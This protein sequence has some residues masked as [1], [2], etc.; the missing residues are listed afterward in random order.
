MSGAPI[1]CID[2]EL[3]LMDG[4]GRRACGDSH[5]PV[6]QLRTMSSALPGGLR[7]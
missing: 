4:P 5:E 1:A 3:R 7:R 2:A 6:S